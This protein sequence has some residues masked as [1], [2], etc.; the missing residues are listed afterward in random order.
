MF[1]AVLGIPMP[2]MKEHEVESASM[3]EEEKKKENT[4]STRLQQKLLSTNKKLRKTV[5]GATVVRD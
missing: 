1:R 2:I 3:V 4:K 5:I